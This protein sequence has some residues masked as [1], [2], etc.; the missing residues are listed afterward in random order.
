MSIH[1]FTHTD[2]ETDVTSDEQEKFTDE[3]DVASAKEEWY[4]DEVDLAI[5]CD[6]EERYMWT[7]PFNTSMTS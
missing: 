6:E 4:T 7:S 1:R 2:D 3:A 5:Q